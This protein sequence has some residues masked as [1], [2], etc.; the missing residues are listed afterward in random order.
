MR[1]KGELAV[2]FQKI[3]DEVAA[4]NGPIRPNTGKELKHVLREF[5]RDVA[6]WDVH[7]E[8]NSEAFRREMALTNRRALL[9]GREEVLQQRNTEASRG[10]SIQNC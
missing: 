3:I 6:S 9:E 8:P 5:K 10:N 2:L 4:R 1:P 7:K